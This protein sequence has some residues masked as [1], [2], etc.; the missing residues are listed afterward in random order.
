MAAV[1]DQQDAAAE[2][3]AQLVAQA[4]RDP[5]VA[6]RGDPD[7]AARTRADHDD[8]VDRDGLQSGAGYPAQ[9]TQDVTVVGCERGGLDQ[10]DTP[11]PSRWRGRVRGLRLLTVLPLA[12]L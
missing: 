1:P 5:E 8:P 3:Q 12:H 11:T 7:C 2:E 10:A 6:I 9:R 4:V